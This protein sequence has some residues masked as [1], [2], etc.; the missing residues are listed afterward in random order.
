MARNFRF[1][2]ALVVIA[3]PVFCS[4]VISCRIGLSLRKT[5]FDL[6]KLQLLTIK[7]NTQSK[8]KTPILI[9]VPRESLNLEKIT[10]SRKIRKTESN[11]GKALIKKIYRIKKKLKTPEKIR[12]FL[13]CPKKKPRS[14]IGSKSAKNKEP[15]LEE[16][17]TEEELL[18]PLAVTSAE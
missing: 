14:E 4:R 3:Q 2:E 15:V 17:L 6:I 18:E 7:R 8:K 11:A 10:A 12:I 16:P 1:W 13:P 9:A 5:V